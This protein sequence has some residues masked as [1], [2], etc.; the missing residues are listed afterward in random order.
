M[1]KAIMMTI[2][3]IKDLQC[4]YI[5]LLIK[6]KSFRT[7]ALRDTVSNVATSTLTFIISA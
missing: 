3:N 1:F 7:L 6:K 2:K 4:L 5:Y